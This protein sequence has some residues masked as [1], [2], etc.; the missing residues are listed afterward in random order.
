MEI[1]DC[2]GLK[3]PEP[4]L[5]VKRHLEEHGGNSFSVVVD[6]EASRENVLRFA[7]S[8][9]CDVSVSAGD[10]NCSLITVNPG[11]NVMRR[12]PLTKMSIRVKFQ[13]EEI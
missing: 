4:V 12:L 5:R 8:Q 11:E 9:G 3:C 7:R 6:N 10:A 2:K 13:M 1:L